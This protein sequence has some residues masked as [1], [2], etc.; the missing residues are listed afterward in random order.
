MQVLHVSVKEDRA[1]IYVTDYTQRDDL[2]EIPATATWTHNIPDN[3]IVK[4]LLTGHAL[5]TVR[6]IGSE[7]Y[8]ALRK[9]RLKSAGSGRQ[10]S[11]RLSGDEQLIFKLDPK[12]SGNR[13]LAFLTKYTRAPLKSFDT[14][15]QLM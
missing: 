2:S 6:T 12:E 15:M 14:L 5:K 10:V 9:V 7:D 11:G 8:V 1:F 13:N 3:R 4:I